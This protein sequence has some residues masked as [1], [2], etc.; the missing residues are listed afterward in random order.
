MGYT[1][2][3]NQRAC[4]RCIGRGDWGS[5]EVARQEYHPAVVT[6]VAVDHLL[7]QGREEK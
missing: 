7:Q 1:G 2:V 4:Q 3:A 6:P 5:A